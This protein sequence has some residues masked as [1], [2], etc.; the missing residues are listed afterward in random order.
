ML[1]GVDLPTMQVFTQ[2]IGLYSS[3]L[4]TPVIIH[5]GERRRALSTLHAVA[6]KHTKSITKITIEQDVKQWGMS[7][8]LDWCY[9]TAIKRK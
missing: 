2:N 6:D 8:R 5:R 7:R 3:H 4:N 9:K 1:K